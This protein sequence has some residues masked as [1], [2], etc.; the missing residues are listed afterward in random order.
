MH[1]SDYKICDTAKVCRETS[2]QHLTEATPT[3]KIELT[4]KA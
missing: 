3:V 1:R 4:R 2:F